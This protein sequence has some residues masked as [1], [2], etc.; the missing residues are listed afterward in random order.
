MMLVDEAW[1]RCGGARRYKSLFLRVKAQLGEHRVSHA[2]LQSRCQIACPH[3]SSQLDHSAVFTADLV[4]SL[5]RLGARCR[6]SM[7]RGGDSRGGYGSDSRGGD[8]RGGGSHGGYSHHGQ[9]EWRDNRQPYH[10]SSSNKDRNQPDP[11]CKLAT[12]FQNT[13]GS[14]K[15]LGEMC[16]LGQTLAAAGTGLPQ[17]SGVAPSVA[18]SSASPEKGSTS[19]VALSE[20]LVRILSPPSQSAGTPPPVTAM[21]V[22]P[23]ALIVEQLRG[24]AAAA[25]A[26][27]SVT[28]HSFEAMLNASASFTRMDARVSGLQ[29]AASEQKIAIDRVS[30]QQSTDSST[31]A[32]IL[33]AVKNGG[34]EPTVP[35]KVEVVPKKAPVTVV[36]PAAHRRFCEK[37]SVGLTREFVKFEEYER[38]VKIGVPFERWSAGVL[39]C[40]S[41]N[42]WIS[43]VAAVCDH[44]AVANVL[45]VA[46]VMEAILKKEPEIL[47]P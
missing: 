22:S 44:D 31:L 27:T 41:L 38:D 11:L 6:E 18:S 30:Q 10:S 17:S 15:S 20:A 19:T 12:D 24:P 28:Q 3:I 21:D 47:N 13:L 16:Q 25:S 4:D 14:L 36:E 1:G 9:K 40:K 23:A 37:F 2:P 7:G 26:P 42:Q 46:D 35:P 43:K 32:E 8:S 33:S 34:R 29:E 45:T 39:R 5:S